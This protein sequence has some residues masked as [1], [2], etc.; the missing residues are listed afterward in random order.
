MR[1]RKTLEQIPQGS[2]LHG[3]TLIELLICITIVIVLAAVVFAMTGKIRTNAQQTSAVSAMRQIGFANV[4][5]YTENNGDINV[6]RD[7]GEWGP[8]EGPGTAWTSNSFMGRMQP[9]LF[10]GID[11]TNEKSL[12]K[13]ITASMSELL[14]TKDLKPWPAPFSA[15]SL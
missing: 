12:N 10:S 6:V 2:P 1:T 15:E 4:A 8:Y 7:R 11:D 13:A 14:G 5:Y 9:F 3:F